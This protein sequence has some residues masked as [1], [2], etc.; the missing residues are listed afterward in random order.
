VAITECTGGPK[1][2]RRWRTLAAPKCWC[3]NHHGRDRGHSGVHGIEDGP[4]AE[5]I[6]GTFRFNAKS[7]E[8]L[9]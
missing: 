7:S 5:K 3:G 1:R 9:D 8:P 6:V 2:S 4:N